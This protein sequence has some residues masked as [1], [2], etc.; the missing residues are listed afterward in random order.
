L[1]HRRDG[2]EEARGDVVFILTLFPQSLEGPELV[3]RVEVDPMHVFGKGTLDL[4]RCRLA[5]DAGDTGG[6][7]E[8]FL[9]DE[10]LEGPVA[11]TAGRNPVE[12]GLVA[13]GVELRPD[14]EAGEQAAPRDVF[15]KLGNR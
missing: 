7:R 5:D 1:P 10:A 2:D 8:P 15:G 4:R 12:T 3:E 9:G 11:A 14:I 6:F 13:I